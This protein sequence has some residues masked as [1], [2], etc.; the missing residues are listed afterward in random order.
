MIMILI[1]MIII[2]NKSYNNNNINDNNDN[3][4]KYNDNDDEDNNTRKIN[5]NYWV[6]ANKFLGLS[7]VTSYKSVWDW[8]R[9]DKN[10]TY[11][12]LISLFQAHHTWIEIS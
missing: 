5:S 6:I 1:K 7:H 3:S 2:I 4:N 11:I 10:G 9:D 8:Q 12:E